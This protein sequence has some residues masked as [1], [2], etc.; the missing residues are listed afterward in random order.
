MALPL[1]P[2]AKDVFLLRYC[3]SFGFYCG[4]R[5]VYS[6]LRV[7]MQDAETYNPGFFLLFSL[8]CDQRERERH[9]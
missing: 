5:S 4:K 8:N 2:F 6:V 7:V 9:L 1:L 3:N